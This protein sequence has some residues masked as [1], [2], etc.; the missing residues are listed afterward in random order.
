V[1]YSN[2]LQAP[3]E[4]SKNVVDAKAQTFDIPPDL[5]VLCSVTEAQVAVSFAQREQMALNRPAVL[6]RQRTHRHSG[7]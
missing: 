5:G 4:N 7:A 6:C 2:Q 3:I 1:S